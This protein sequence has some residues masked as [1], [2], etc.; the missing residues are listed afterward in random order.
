MK[1]TSQPDIR[2]WGSNS[3]NKPFRLFYL[4]GDLMKKL[5]DLAKPED[6]SELIAE[7]IR[8]EHARRYERRS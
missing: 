7:L 1:S 4:S 5:D 6:Q 2:Q 3:P 8:Q